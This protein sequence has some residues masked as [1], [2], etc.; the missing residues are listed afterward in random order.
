MIVCLDLLGKNKEERVKV[1]GNAVVNHALEVI[2]REAGIEI[3]RY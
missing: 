3:S 1:R 2:E